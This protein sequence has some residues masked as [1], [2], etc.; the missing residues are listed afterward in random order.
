MPRGPTGP[1]QQSGLGHGRFP[2]HLGSEHSGALP[3]PSYPSGQ[4]SGRD[5]REA[6]ESS[7]SGQG[8]LLQEQAPPR[9]SPS[10]Q[11]SRGAQQLF[12]QAWLPSVPTSA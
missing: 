8:A 9:V 12:P 3:R 10:L 5:T 2:L 7:V 1:W 4:R 11:P 6:Q